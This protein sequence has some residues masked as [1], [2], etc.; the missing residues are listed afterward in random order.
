MTG[1]SSIIDTS[2]NGLYLV[3]KLIDNGCEYLADVNDPLIRKD[4]LPRINVSDR[5][6]SEN[7][8]RDKEG[9]KIFTEIIKMELD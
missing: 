1:I 3:H 4:K 5:K 2:S 6:L 7:T 8:S 9:Y